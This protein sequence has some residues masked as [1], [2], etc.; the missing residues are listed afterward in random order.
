MAYDNPTPSGSD[1]MDSADQGAAATQLETG[2]G[3]G[4]EQGAP[5]KTEQEGAEGQ[6]SS[7]FITPDMLPP[8]MKVNAGDVL[9]FKVVN[10][11]DADGH[12][13]VVYNT[14]KEGESKESWEDEFRHTMSARSPQEGAM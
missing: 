8:G 1:E 6:E 10:P 3:P 7:L 4:E 12:I 5:E 9:E 14:G 11:S 13:E 2:P